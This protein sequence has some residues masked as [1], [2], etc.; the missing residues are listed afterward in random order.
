MKHFTK[1]ILIIIIFTFSSRTSHSYERIVCIGSNITEFVI[2]L[3]FGDKIVATD[4][5]SLYPKQAEDIPKIGF[6]KGINATK[7]LNENPDLII[8]R[9]KAGTFISMA[10]LKAEA[11]DFLQVP[12]PSD[13]D[14]V[15]GV[16][17]TIAA[18]LQVEEKGE[19]LIKEL[20]SHLI[21]IEE[22]VANLQIIPRA[23]YVSVD[24]TGN[25]LAY[26]SEMPSH[27]M[28]VLGGGH[29]LMIYNKNWM[30]VDVSF[31]ANAEIDV[32][33]IENNNLDKVGG[34]DKFIKDYAINTTSAGKNNLIIFV[35]G[36]AFNNFGLR[37]TENLAKVVSAYQR[38]PVNNNKGQ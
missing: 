13:F 8:A 27:N 11:K 24:E 4:N 6:F 9:E 35:D 32:I 21:K 25:V 5:E 37:F 30:K 2:E 3:G 29:N 33:F 7:V 14:G 34:L 31:F 10:Q 23:L 16:I 18:K 15:K 20:E 22:Q 12:E 26:G 1:L 19:E 28:I 36:I 17:R 38:V